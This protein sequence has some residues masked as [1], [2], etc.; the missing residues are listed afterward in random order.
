MLAFSSDDHVLEMILVELLE[1]PSIEWQTLVATTSE[2]APSW[3][4]P[5]VAFLFDGS[6]PTDAKEVE[7]VRRALAR[8]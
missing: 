8:F 6:L 5:Y 2:L 3:M 1:H 4:D 7:K